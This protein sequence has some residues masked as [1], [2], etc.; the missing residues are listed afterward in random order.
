MLLVPQISAKKPKLG[1]CRAA[2]MHQFQ[3]SLSSVVNSSQI[4][5]DGHESAI[6]LRDRS[7]G[8]SAAMKKQ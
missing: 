7:R 6:A 1:H 2:T 3:D 8:R 5:I 4:L